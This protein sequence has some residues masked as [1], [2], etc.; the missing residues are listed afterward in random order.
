MAIVRMLDFSNATSWF[1]KAIF[2]SHMTT[3]LAG[4]CRTTV[5]P[6][7]C[8]F[9]VD[10][11]HP[12]VYSHFLW[13]SASFTEPVQH[14]VVCQLHGGCVNAT[15]TD[16]EVQGFG[17]PLTTLAVVVTNLTT[18]SARPVKGTHFNAGTMDEPTVSKAGE[19]STAHEVIAHCHA[20]GN[21]EHLPLIVFTK[22]CSYVTL[23]H[24]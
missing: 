1:L 9:A 21:F 19:R 13:H 16:Y 11:L 15:V 17:C 12:L 14:R 8:Q 3:L 18:P 7:L 20:R 24:R 23:R 10:A 5:R 6:Q 22:E 4:S 2:T